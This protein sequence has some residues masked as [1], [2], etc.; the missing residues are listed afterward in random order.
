MAYRIA[1]RKNHADAI[2][3][4]DYRVSEE[5]VGV[6]VTARFFVGGDSTIRTLEGCHGGGSPI[7]ALVHALLPLGGGDEMQDY[8]EYPGVSGEAGVSI[9][10]AVQVRAVYGG[11]GWG[12]GSGQKSIDAALK[13]LVGAAQSLVRD[14]AAV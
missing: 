8:T 3:F 6:R 2:T 5:F 13:A 7:V 12:M 4:L 9:T 14:C 1:W 10:A 11:T